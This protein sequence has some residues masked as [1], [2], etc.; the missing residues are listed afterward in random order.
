LQT[1][2]AKNATVHLRRR[3][4]ISAQQ[5]DREPHQIFLLDTNLRC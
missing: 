4:M 5:I 2:V 1:F 3:D